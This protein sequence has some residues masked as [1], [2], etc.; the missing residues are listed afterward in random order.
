M[1]KNTLDINKY[2]SR[3]KYNYSSD[4]SL[5]H[6]HEEYQYLNLL[7]DILKEGII[8]KGRNGFTKCIYGSALHFSLEN[9]KIPIFTTKKTAWKTCLKELLW[10]IKGQTSNK[11]L[12]DQNV[13]IWDGNSTKEFKESRGLTHYNDNDLGPLYGFQWRFFNAPYV[14]CD[15]NYEGNGYDQLAEVIESLKDPEKKYSRRLVVSA[16]NPNQ[17]NEGVLPP[18]HVLFQFN[19]IGNKLSCSLY[20]RSCDCPLGQPFNITSYSFLTHLIAKHCDLEPYEFIHYI[21]NAHIYEPHLKQME[22]QI[23]RKPKEFPNIEILNKREN[24]N[25]YVL[26]DFKISEYNHHPSIKM[27]MVA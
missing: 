7:E 9:N 6:Y 20:Q 21:G 15:T 10:F 5:N 2:K 1:L 12:N 13:H 4:S 24:I 22:Q 17:I 8:Q 25:E 23:E 11:I 16:W 18:C 3:N 27:N 19:V 26:S 14:N